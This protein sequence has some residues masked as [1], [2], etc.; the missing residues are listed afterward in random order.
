MLGEKQEY[1]SLKEAARKSGYSA[2]Y[3]GQLIRSGKL[4]GKQIY[5]NV[6]WV[7]TE[8]ALVEYMQKE[9]KNQASQLAGV[10]LKDRVRTL[11]KLTKVYAIAAWTAVAML[12]VFILLLVYILIAGVEQRID[13]K[14][15]HTVEYAQ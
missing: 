11:Q 13:Q 8:A 4:A 3:V 14:H 12:S 2:D 1:I 9:R 10:S 6:A 5:S 7:T 15:L